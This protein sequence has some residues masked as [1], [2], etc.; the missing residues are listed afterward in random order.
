M[1]KHAGIGEVVLPGVEE[2]V[3]QQVEASRLAESCRRVHCTDVERA[4]SLPMSSS[5]H[6]VGVAA[7]VGEGEVLNGTDAQQHSWRGG[8]VDRGFV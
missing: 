6:D 8:L 7:A 1:G 2:E 4:G 5:S 3:A